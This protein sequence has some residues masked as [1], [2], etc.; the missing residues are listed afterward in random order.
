MRSCYKTGQLRLLLLSVRVIY[1]KWP[2]NSFISGVASVFAVLTDEISLCV[3]KARVTFVQLRQLWHRPELS[4]FLSCRV[5]NAAVQA[6]F[7]LL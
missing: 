5:Y 1:W 3:L 2:T 6:V 7:D 4:L